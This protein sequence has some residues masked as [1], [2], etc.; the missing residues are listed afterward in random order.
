MLH[1]I[2]SWNIIKNNPFWI[3]LYLFDTHTEVNQNIFGWFCFYHYQLQLCCYHFKINCTFL[4]LSADGTKLNFII[5]CVF[6]APDAYLYLSYYV[7]VAKFFQGI[8]LLVTFLSFSLFYSICLPWMV[9]YVVVL[10]FW[11]G[12]GVHLV[13]GTWV[14]GNLM[15]S[16]SLGLDFELVL[17]WLLQWMLM[18]LWI[19][20]QLLCRHIFH[21][22]LLFLVKQHFLTFQS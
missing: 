17:E 6:H 21:S 13:I 10:L 1:I 19:Y 14:V 15:A 2:H 5:N 22:H 16:L 18:E 11:R 7:S 20:F 4:L 12:S 3:F 9:Y 8:L